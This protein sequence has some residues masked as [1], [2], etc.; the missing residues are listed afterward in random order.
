MQ[1]LREKGCLGLLSLVSPLLLSSDNTEQELTGGRGKE[2][3][4]EGEGEGGSVERRK[5]KR[6]SGLSLVVITKRTQT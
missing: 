2:V 5:C 1:I 3:G 4:C 6:E